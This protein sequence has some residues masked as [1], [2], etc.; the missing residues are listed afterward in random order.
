MLSIMN[1]YVAK[2]KLV[3]DDVTKGILGVPLM[4]HPDVLEGL[5]HRKAN[6]FVVDIRLRA[7]STETAVAVM[8]QFM[9]QTRFHY[10]AYFIRFNEGDMLRYRYATCRENREGFY[11]DV[12]IH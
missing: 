8:N 6:H 3:S 7:Y 5:V 1:E 11:C 4:N 2:I 9:E 10:S 12:V